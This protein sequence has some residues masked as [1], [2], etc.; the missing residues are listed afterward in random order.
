MI[1]VQALRIAVTQKTTREIGSW[2]ANSGPLPA[3]KFKEFQK[4]FL[5]GLNEVESFLKTEGIL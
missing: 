1:F 5:D 3:D 4:V 2:V